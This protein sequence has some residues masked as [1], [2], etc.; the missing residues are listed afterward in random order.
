MKTK[1]MFAYICITCAVIAGIASATPITFIQTGT[2]SGTLNGVPFGA[3]SFIITSQGNTDDRQSW[4]SGLW[5][6]IHSSSS[7]MIT[8]LGTFDVLEQTRTFVNNPNG[9]VGYFIGRDLFNIG[10][11]L[12][13]ETWNMLRPIGPIN[14]QG[15]LLQWGFIPVNTS[16]GILFFNDSYM[17]AVFKA[18]PEPATL[19]LL[20]FGG[21]LLRRKRNA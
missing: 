7:I 16:G 17:A 3:T 11:G 10:P 6:I 9:L 4:G 21:M 2:G 13:F 19:L 12:E 15:R 5:C 18:V 8:G 1:T 14:S 20:A